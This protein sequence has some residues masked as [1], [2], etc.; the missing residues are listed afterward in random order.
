MEY[1][2]EIKEGHDTSSYFWFR[3]VILKESEKLS[4]DGVIELEEEFSIEE[5]DVECF[6]SYFF[7]KYF[8]ENLSYNK[9]RY[10][11][12]MGYISGFEWYL[13]YNFFTYDTLKEMVK[14]I[15]ET[16][17]LLESD[18][19]NPRLDDIKKNFS[20]FYMCDRDDYDYINCEHTAI[21]EHISVVIDFYRRF[22]KRITAMMENNKITTIISI[23]GP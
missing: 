1:Q 16:A 6:L 18:Y 15:E 17:A 9:R 2:I 19:D 4:D 22:S 14:E 11:W 12:G 21:R 8:D 23:M 3:P 20:I 10:E 7:Y 5:G 13:T